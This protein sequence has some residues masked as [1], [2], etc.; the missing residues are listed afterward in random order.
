MI[1]TDLT[2]ATLA[3]A[4]VDVLKKPDAPPF[5]LTPMQICVGITGEALESILQ[6]A[7]DNKIKVF[8]EIDPKVGFHSILFSLSFSSHFTNWY[9][10]NPIRR[11]AS[12]RNLRK[13]FKSNLE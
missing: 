8:D 9:I 10:A 11:G 13:C 5:T 12:T 4:L 2:K 6:L 3:Q 7:K 1:K